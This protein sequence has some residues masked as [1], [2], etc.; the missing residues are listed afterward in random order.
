MCKKCTKC[1]KEYENNIKEHFHKN[2]LTKDGLNKICKYCKL[3]N[4]HKI[5]HL[6]IN[7]NIL[8]TKCLIYKEDCNF[9]NALGK[10]F[11]KE[12]DLRC[13]DCKKI[14][15]EKRRIN[16]RGDLGIERLL[17]ERYAALKDR[18][19]KNGLIVD[20][21]KTY[22][23]ELW[24]KQNYTCALSGIKMTTL[25]FKGRVNTNMSVDRIDNSKGYIKGNIQLVCM[26][27]NQMKNDL[28]QEALLFFCNKIIE[29]EKKN[30]NR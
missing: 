14:Q 12:K 17:T 19:K 18:A 29:N 8:C 9:D 3:N 21:E 24:E 5:K 16:N 7:G 22:L 30:N 2:T 25:F 1:N 27:I 28:S 15:Y 20:F 6:D 26:A 13:K 10:W 11:R 23:K 4:R